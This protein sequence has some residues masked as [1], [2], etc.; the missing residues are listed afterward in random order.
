MRRI[1]MDTTEK[2]IKLYS[3]DSQNSAPLFLSILN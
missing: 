1:E 3:P 2:I